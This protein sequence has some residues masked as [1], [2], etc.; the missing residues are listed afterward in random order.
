[1]F[2]PVLEETREIVP[3]WEEISEDD[4]EYQAWVNTPPPQ[5][6]NW[7]GL[8]NSLRGTAI[9]HKI[10]TGSPNYFSVLNVALTSTRNLEDFIW[11][12]EEIRPSMVDDFT[13]EEITQI[14]SWLEQSNFTLRLS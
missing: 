12:L 8:L 13:P 5:P 9:F 7:E 14:N 4:I 3:G 11:A 2:P 6:P 10:L 1:M